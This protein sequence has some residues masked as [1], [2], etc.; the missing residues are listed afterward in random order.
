MNSLNSKHGFP[1]SQAWNKFYRY[2]YHRRKITILFYSW[3]ASLFYSIPWSCLICFAM[4]VARISLT[5]NSLDRWGNSLLSTISSV[6]FFLSSS[7]N[8]LI[9][10]FSKT[11]SFYATLASWVLFLISKSLLVPSSW[12][13][14]YCGLH[15]GWELQWENEIVPLHQGLLSTSMMSDSTGRATN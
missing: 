14:I 1:M 7:K 5:I 2:S 15:H 9:C 11:D 3:S 12:K 8:V 4:S 10:I 13:N 6:G